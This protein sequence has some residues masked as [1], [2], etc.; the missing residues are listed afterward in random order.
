MAKRKSPS[1][2]QRKAKVRKLPNHRLR[3]ILLDDKVVLYVNYV[4][5]ILNLMDE[6]E[7]YPNDE[8]MNFM[9]DIDKQIRGDH[10]FPTVEDMF[11][12]VCYLLVDVNESNNRTKK[13]LLKMFIGWMTY[14]KRDLTK[15]VQFLAK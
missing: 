11:C 15:A 4:K 13:S 9:R 5:A 10:N 8:E 12:H 6:G 7:E 14:H 3:K 1:R 2:K